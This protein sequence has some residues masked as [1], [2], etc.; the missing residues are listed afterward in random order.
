M[1][2]EA[3]N[4]ERAWEGLG[5]ELQNRANGFGDIKHTKAGHLAPGEAMRIA[6]HIIE[7]DKQVTATTFAFLAYGDDNGKHHQAASSSLGLMAQRGILKR[8]GT[9]VFVRRPGTDRDYIKER[10]RAAKKVKEEKESQSGFHL[11]DVLEVVG[12]WKGHVVLRNM[13]RP[14]E[15]QVVTDGTG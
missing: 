9:G 14:A 6:V 7:R 4:Q 10:A 13:D 11:G 12:F 3:P 8:S 2:V 15:I 5:V 1:T